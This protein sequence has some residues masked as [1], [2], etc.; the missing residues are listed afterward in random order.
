MIVALNEGPNPS[1]YDLVLE[2]TFDSQEEF[3]HY[4]QHEEH[5]AVWQSLLEP[6]TLERAGIQFN[7]FA[8]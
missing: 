2:A 1:N 4:V 5:Q 3:L 6:I 7:D 8:E